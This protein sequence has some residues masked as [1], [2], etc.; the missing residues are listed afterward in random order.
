MN[1]TMKKKCIIMGLS[2]LLAGGLALSSCTE[3]EENT[4][5]P[6]GTEYYI[7][8]IL[9]VIPDSL[10]TRF[11]AEFGSIPEGPVPPKI[12]GSY[13][14]N[15]K[16]RVGSNVA[17]WPL[18]P[19]EEDLLMR[20]STQHNELITLTLKEAT[21][22]FTDTV[23][24]C[25][26]GNGFA[27]YFIENLEYDLALDTVSYHVNMKRGVIMKGKMAAD[28]IADFRYAT[29][30]METSDNSHGLIEQYPNGSYFIYKDGDGKAENFDW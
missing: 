20:F 16:Q 27:V 29:I 17:G 11:L 13:K 26:N 4:I 6:I 15:P 24:V 25:G 14:V 23:F 18:H 5:V 7:D 10:E 28:G 22:N 30:I 21:E 1:E 2:L 8:D 3:N 9:S 12:E 19:I